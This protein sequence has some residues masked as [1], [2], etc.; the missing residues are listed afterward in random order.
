MSADRVIP[1]YGLELLL[2]EWLVERTEES[3]I[4]QP[5]A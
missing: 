4:R 5:G 2:I 3:C 1:A